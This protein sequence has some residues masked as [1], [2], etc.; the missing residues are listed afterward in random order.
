MMKGGF[1]RP[2]SL[3]NQF[4]GHPEGKD[5]GGNRVFPAVAMTFLVHVNAGENEKYQ[6][7][8]WKLVLPVIGK[9]LSVYPAMTAYSSAKVSES[10]LNTDCGH[11]TWPR[12]V[13][14]LAREP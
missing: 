6:S 4:I 10:K 5:V 8:D 11:A 13:Q 12:F 2:P 9:L 3:V 14:L 1:N 7:N